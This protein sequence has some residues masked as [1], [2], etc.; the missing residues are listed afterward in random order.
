MKKHLQKKFFFKKQ[1]TFASYNSD[2][3]AQLVKQMGLL[4]YN[5]DR[6]EIWNTPQK[7]S[8]YG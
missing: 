2:F 8:S 4:V 3:L 6:V 5:E 7:G 1:I